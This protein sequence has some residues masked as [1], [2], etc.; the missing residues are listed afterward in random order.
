MKEYIANRK[1]E[2]MGEK[3]VMWPTTTNT[4]FSSF[5][6]FHAGND[7][8]KLLLQN[9]KKK[10]FDGTFFVLRRT[11]KRKIIFSWS[12]DFLAES[13]PSVVLIVF[14]VNRAWKTK[15]ISNIILFW[16]SVH[17]SYHNNSSSNIQTFKFLKYFKDNMVQYLA[18]K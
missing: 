5:L 8:H 12:G 18:Q 13:Y 6:F 10:Y 2:R 14:L 7:S 17:V 1:V 3:A 16:R 15:T 11:M 4:F 9:K